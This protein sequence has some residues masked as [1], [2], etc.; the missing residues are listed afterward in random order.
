[1]IHST[2]IMAG[3]NDSC[4]D[5]LMVTAHLLARGR[6]ARRRHW[7][8]VP[9]VRH[10]RRVPGGGGGTRSQSCLARTGAGDA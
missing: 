10:C 1:M 5:Q 3:H 6:G 9:E 8:A 4:D 2:V 7:A